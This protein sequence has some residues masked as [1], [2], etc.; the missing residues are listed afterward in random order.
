V[1]RGA[2]RLARKSGVKNE[3]SSEARLL[4]KDGQLRE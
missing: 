3:L 4:F 2:G 1:V